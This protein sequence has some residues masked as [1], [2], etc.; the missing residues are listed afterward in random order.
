MY[1]YV[2]PD[3]PGL[4]HFPYLA[5][6]DFERQLESFGDCWG[7]V[8]REGFLDWVDGGPAPDGVL[9][10]FDDGLRDH[11]DFVLPQLSA[12]GLF[13]LF[14]VSSGPVTEGRFLDVHKLHLALGRI[15][16]EATLD[17]LRA[18]VP[19]TTAAFSGFDDGSS[20]YATQK[21]DTATRFVKSLFNWKLPVDERSSLLDSLLVDAF[22]GSPPDW[23][24]YYLD[25]PD[26]RKISS[27]GMGVGAHGHRH[28]VPSLLS[29]EEQKKEVDA[30]TAFLDT[31]GGS[32]NWG[33]CYPH[34]VPY[35]EAAITDAGYPFAFGVSP[36]DVEGTLRC[37][38]RYDLPR[39][40]CN[41]FAHGSV[42]YDVRPGLGR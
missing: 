17:W 35:A 32:R 10:T 8:G 12:R 39:H 28:I 11:V 6:A 13:G 37:E 4:P 20:P 1:H 30:S 42:S 24:E 25:D 2:R 18:R 3:A 29:S 5:L 34:G 27:A 23:R 36:S 22:D 19:Q 15:G 40:N 21:A 9:L 14:Y 41:A 16:G 7:F 38:H 33:Y 31:V 26:I